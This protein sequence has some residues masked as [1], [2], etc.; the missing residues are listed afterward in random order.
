M[1]GIELLTAFLGWSVVISLGIY[2]ISVTV[3][4]LMRG[5]VLRMNARAFGIEEEEVAKVLFR[6]VTQYKLA[7][8]VLF[9]T[10]WLALKVIA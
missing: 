5:L 10:P 2:F 8:A 6:V 1:E 3:I 4:T 9:F 7:I